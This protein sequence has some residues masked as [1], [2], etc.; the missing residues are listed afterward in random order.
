MTIT[1]NVHTHEDRTVKDIAI[2]IRVV[3]LIMAFWTPFIVA[4]GVRAVYG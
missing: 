2:G 1:N 4:L 3:A